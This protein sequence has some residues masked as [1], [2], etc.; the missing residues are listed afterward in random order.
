M[1]DLDMTIDVTQFLKGLESLGGQLPDITADAAMAGV[2]VARQWMG[3]EIAKPKSGK[4]YKVNRGRQ[5]HQ[6]SAPGEAPAMETGNL[7]NSIA[8]ELQRKDKTGATAAVIVLAEYGIHLEFGTEDMEP[9]PFLR[10]AF[11]QNRKEIMT[12]VANTFKGWKPRL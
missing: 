1:S 7:V 11:D 6:A 3:V 12:A 5:T 8:E 9:R 10:P 4:V 2:H